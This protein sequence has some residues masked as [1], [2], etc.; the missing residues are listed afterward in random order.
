M[1][2]VN[3]PQWKHKSDNDEVRRNDS[4]PSTINEGSRHSTKGIDNQQST[5]IDKVRRSQ[6]NTTIYLLIVDIN[7]PVAKQQRQHLRWPTKYQ[8]ICGNRQLSAIKNYIPPKQRLQI[9]RQIKMK[10][11]KDVGRTSYPKA[12]L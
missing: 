11:G 9:N 8:T 12:T 2:N 3:Y 10:R 4:Q 7:I 6:V 5:F 1:D